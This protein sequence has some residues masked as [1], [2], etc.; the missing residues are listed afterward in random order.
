MPYNGDLVKKVRKTMAQYPEVEEKE[1]MGGL[2][3][4]LNGK[5][6]V[7]VQDNDLMVRC[8]PE[9]TEE[10]LAKKGARRYTM[11]GK[12]NMKGWLLI[13]PE[14]TKSQGDFDFWMGITIDFNTLIKR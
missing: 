9:K 7:R 1:K 3:F 14:G 5:M 12:T 10:L 11:K 2:S 4:M 13:G 6:C 8:K